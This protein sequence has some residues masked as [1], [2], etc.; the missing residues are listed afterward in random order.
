MVQAIA[1]IVVGMH[2]SNK[3]AWNETR[4]LMN[5]LVEGMLAVGTRLTPN[6]RPSG[7]IDFVARACDVPANVDET[8]VI[9]N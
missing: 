5:Q 4:T 3:V 8:Y 6:N 2:W 1:N 9:Q 7:I